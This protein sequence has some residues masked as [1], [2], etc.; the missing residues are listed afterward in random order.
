MALIQL[1]SSPDINPEP[2][3]VE[4]FKVHSRITV[5]DEDADIALKLTA[6]RLHTENFL[7]RALITS[8]WQK[9]IEDWPCYR[10]IVLG[11]NVQSIESVF[12]TDSDGEES[13]MPAEDYRLVRA[14]TSGPSDVKDGR[15]QLRYSKYWPSAV[16]DEG[17]PIR[18]TFT[19]G[20]LTADDVPEPIK[21]AIHLL[22]GH[23]YEHRESVVIGENVT[24]ESKPLEMAYEALLSPYQIVRVG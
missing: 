18:V 3:S 14:Y 15:I 12:Y 10:Y 24:I 1:A 22:A 4:E 21:A 20:W 7:G 13:E 2:V 23:L 8:R 6:A 11:A 17:E 19:A 9:W 16:L 5:T